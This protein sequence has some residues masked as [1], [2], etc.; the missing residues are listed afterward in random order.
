MA[1]FTKA[2]NKTAKTEGGWVNDP[3]DSGGETWKGISRNN[4]PKWEGW[5]LIDFEK[6]NL[7]F[8]VAPSKEEIKKLNAILNKSE[9]L[10]LC[11]R[12]F[13]KGEFWDKVRGDELK[14]QEVGDSLY[15]SSVNFG[16][17]KAIKIAQ[18]AL[19]IEETGE[20]DEKTFKLINV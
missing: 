10:E 8:S 9:K 12:K 15:D 18:A 14:R 2:Y 16:W 19:K 13:F 3:D 7:K 11:V 20:M 17:R 6:S 1:D 5:D 4:F